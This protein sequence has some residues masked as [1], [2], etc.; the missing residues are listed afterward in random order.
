[1]HVQGR[2]VLANMLKREKLPVGI[3]AKANAVRSHDQVAA[4]LTIA[5]ADLGGVWPIMR[6][7]KALAD[8]A[9]AA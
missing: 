7:T 6:V 1:M 9:D 8:I 4:A 2:R 3:V 5:L